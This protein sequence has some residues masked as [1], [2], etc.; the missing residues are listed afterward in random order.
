MRNK[1]IHIKSVPIS[2][3]ILLKGQFRFIS[4]N[5]LKKKYILQIRESCK[6]SKLFDILKYKCNFEHIK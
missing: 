6:N 2:L 3:K 4:E 5:K 1:L